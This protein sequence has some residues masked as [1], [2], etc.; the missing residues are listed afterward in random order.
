MARRGMGWH[1]MGG[2]LFRSVSTTGYVIWVG[3]FES[4]MH[5]WVKRGRALFPT[6]AAQ[7]SSCYGGE[8]ICST[9]ITI[10]FLGRHEK[11]FNQRR[12]LISI[13]RIL[14]FPLPRLVQ[15]GS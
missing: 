12:C 13:V 14:N 15:F 5:F 7:S 4:A 6:R 2:P 9:L 1:G 3:D 11:Q 10:N 8:G